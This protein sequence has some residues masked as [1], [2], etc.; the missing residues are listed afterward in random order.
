MDDV[1]YCRRLFE[2]TANRKYSTE[3]ECNDVDCA[4]CVVMLAEVYSTQRSVLADMADIVF[5]ALRR[6]LNWFM[7]SFSICT[8][9]REFL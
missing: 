3:P 6:G 1:P 7:F 5:I 9:I 2:M 4:Y 8:C